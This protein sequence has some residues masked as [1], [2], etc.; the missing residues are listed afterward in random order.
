MSDHRWLTPPAEVVPAHP[1]LNPETS[2]LARRIRVLLSDSLSPLA[3]SIRRRMRKTPMKIAAGICV[4]GFIGLM[5]VP[6][7]FRDESRLADGSNHWSFSE[8]SFELREDFKR[9]SILWSPA[10]RHS[11]VLPNA[12]SDTEVAGGE[13]HEQ[14]L[15]QL[16]SANADN[17]VASTKALSTLQQTLSGG[18]LAGNET[19]KADS[20]RSYSASPRPSKPEGWFAAPGQER[21]DNEGRGTLMF[22]DLSAPAVSPNGTISQPSTSLGDNSLQAL[23]GRAGV[24]APAADGTGVRTDAFDRAPLLAGVTDMPA[25]PEPVAAGD[26][27]DESIPKLMIKSE[28]ES[29]GKSLSLAVTDSEKTLD[30]VQAGMGEHPFADNAA[31]NGYA[32]WDQSGNAVDNKSDGEQ[33]GKEPETNEALGLSGDA[34]NFGTMARGLSERSDESRVARGSGLLRDRLA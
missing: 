22:G 19:E 11:L 5:T 7:F 2:T 26:A 4:A 32:A 25:S 16:D 28:E 34:S 1:G 24:N 30:D 33:P 15:T 10:E 9:R 20:F 31:S 13:I 12:S 8:D 18:G 29:I 23:N 27:I 14:L 21:F 6:S 3:S 17:A